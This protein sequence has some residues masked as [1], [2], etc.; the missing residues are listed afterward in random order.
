VAERFWYKSKLRNQS[1]RIWS[2]EI[3]NSLEFE[4]LTP[5]LS[6][7]GRGSPTEF[8]GTVLAH[9]NLTEA[10]SLV[11]QETKRLRNRLLIEIATS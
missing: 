11:I 9:T 1:S 5:T 8:V 2:D 6:P 10:E 7:T 4:P 3:P